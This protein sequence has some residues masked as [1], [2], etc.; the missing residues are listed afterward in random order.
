MVKGCSQSQCRHDPACLTCAKLNMSLSLFV[1]LK[2][3]QLLTLDLFAASWGQDRLP[4]TQASAR[5]LSSSMLRGALSCDAF[6][7][8]VG[9]N[10]S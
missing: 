3:D 8:R 1:S 10:E 7:A 5:L 9:R 4:P 6:S 2:T